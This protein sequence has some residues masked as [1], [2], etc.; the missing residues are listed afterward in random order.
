MKVF[1]KRIFRT[2][3]YEDSRL[4]VQHRKPFTNILK[5]SNYE[6]FYIQK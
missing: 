5:T 2:F 4:G 6:L 3:T 1:Q